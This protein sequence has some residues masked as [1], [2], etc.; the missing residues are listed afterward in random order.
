M[1]ATTRAIWASMIEP[2]W[3]MSISISRGPWKTPLIDCTSN[4]PS[5]SSSRN[6]A[7]LSSRVWNGL[8]GVSLPGVKVIRFG[9]E[10][11]SDPPGRS[12]RKHSVM[13]CG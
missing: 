8:T 4:P 12:T 3:R 6:S 10:I 2:P 1:S 9:V 7:A 13:N 5:M 11:S